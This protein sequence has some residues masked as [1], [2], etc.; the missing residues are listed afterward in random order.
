MSIRALIIDDEPLARE[1]IRA[2]VAREQDVEIIGESASGI[3]A[4]ADI[5]RLKPDLVFLDV[6]MPGLDGFGVL[7]AIGPDRMP[8]TIFVT[9]HDQYA[10]RAFDVHALDYLLKPFDRKRFQKSL[11]RARHALDRSRDPEF[12]RRLISLL[13]D[14]SHESQHLERIVV[15]EEGRLFFVAVQDVDWCEAAGNYIRLHVGDDEHLVRET[16]ASFEG[17]LDPNRFVRIHRSTIINIDR[18]QE[19]QPAFHGDYVV[20]LRNGKELIMSRGFRERVQSRLKISF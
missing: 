10:L 15:K 14:V 3:E 7:K 13:Q 19:L 6:Q 11:N 17:K 12:G 9:A 5:R 20:V 16:M 8:A 4:V 1:R 2:L 18:V